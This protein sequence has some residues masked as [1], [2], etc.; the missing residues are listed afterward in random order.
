MKKL[1]FLTDFSEASTRALRYYRNAYATE[2]CEFTILHCYELPPEA[3]FHVVSRRLLENV[4]GKMRR[5]LEKAQ[6][7]GTPLL[8]QFEGRVLPGPSGRVV[9]MLC[10]LEAYDQVLVGTQPEAGGRGGS[11]LPGKRKLYRETIGC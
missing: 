10:A 9:A 8:H 3:T 6:R 11:S 1:L 7:A 4:Q 2:A 5:F